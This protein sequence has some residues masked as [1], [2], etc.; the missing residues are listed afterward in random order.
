MFWVQDNHKRR[1]VW[2]AHLARESRAGRPCYLRQRVDQTLN[3]PV[4]PSFPLDL[5]SLTQNRG[6]IRIA[7]ANQ[8]YHLL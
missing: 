4:E 3:E 1:V 7:R 5:N 8:L 6:R 2:H